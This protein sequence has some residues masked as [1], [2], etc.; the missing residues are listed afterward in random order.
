MLADLCGY[1]TVAVGKNHFGWNTTGDYVTHGFQHLKVYDALGDEL[2][3]DDYR[4]YFDNLHP[5][6]DPL[7]VT[8]NHLG[9]NEWKACPY[10]SSKEEEHP[11]VWTTREAL[12]YLESFDFSNPENTFFLR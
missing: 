4:T 10:G 3:F 9:Y 5:G 12:K 8:C 6:V 2:R 11:T 7:G 1:E